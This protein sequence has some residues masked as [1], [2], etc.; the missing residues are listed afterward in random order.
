M[1]VHASP[2]HAW[3]RATLLLGVG[4]L[5]IGRVFALPT[6]HVRAWRLAAWVISGIAFAAHIGYEHFRL[7]D[8][9]RVTAVHVALAVAIGAAGLAIA[10]LVHS[11]STAAGLRPVW[12]LAIVL[13]P[14]VTA[15]PAFLVAL[16][17]TTMLA[18]LER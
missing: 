6:E 10:G 4:Y 8:T 15:I 2:S 17:A 11:L 3:V 5:L 9:P 1:L 13:L 16:A 12:F 7:R 18:R 14:A